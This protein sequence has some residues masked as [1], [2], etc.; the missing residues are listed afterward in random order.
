M[1][2]GGAGTIGQ[3]LGPIAAYCEREGLP[4]LNTLA[5]G[6]DTG[7]PSNGTFGKDT[8][9]ERE[10][11]FQHPWFEVYPPSAGNFAEAFTEAQESGWD[12]SIL[13]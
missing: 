10:R 8:N 11:V 13:N 3:L 4:V 6:K 12:F 2:Y 7:V 5:V 1:G 9:V